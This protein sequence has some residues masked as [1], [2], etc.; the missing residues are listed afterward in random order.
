MIHD[1]NPTLGRQK[2]E[3]MWLTGN[4]T[5]THRLH[6]TY[7]HTFMPHNTYTHSCHTIHAHTH[8]ICTYTYQHIC[9]YTY[10]HMHT[11]RSKHSTHH[12]YHTHVYVINV[13]RICVY[14]YIHTPQYV[15]I[16]VC[17]YMRYSWKSRISYFLGWI[18]KISRPR[19]PWGT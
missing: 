19:P 11:Q 3:I 13:S 15:Y 17:I 2:Q 6:T 16:Y 10:I 9:I 7:T 12:I 14:V 8:H 18:R 1:Y 4:N 5:Q